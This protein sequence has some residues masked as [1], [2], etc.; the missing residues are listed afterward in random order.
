MS[1]I[2]DDY[3]YSRYWRG[4]EYEDLAEKR[5]LI[6]FFKKIPS[7][8]SLIDI[9]SG[10]GRFTKIY[11]PLFENCLLVDHSQKNLKRA[12]KKNKKFSHLE[13]QIASAINLPAG[14]NAF[15]VALMIR[16]SHHLTNLS[17]AVRETYRVLKPSGY[18]IFEFAN[19]I[20]LKSVIKAFLKGNLEYL[21]SHLPENISSK[22]GVNFFN[23]HPSHIKSL[24]ITNNFEIVKTR[25]VS[26]FRHPIFKKILPL[27]LLLLM[28]TM[29]SV[30]TAHLLP[31][32]G[33]SIFILAK[34]R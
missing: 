11:A 5:A 34:K 26:N 33:P 8:K 21:L 30:L 4:R 22:K 18:L 25:S 3:D 14:N 27:R 29:F 19:K 10:F 7:K 31:F 2:Y 32:Y 6:R 28:E 1:V 15:D 24:L 16:V 23:Y 20:H 13:Y 9:G 17:K 12:R